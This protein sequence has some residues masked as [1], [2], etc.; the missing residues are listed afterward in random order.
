MVDITSEAVWTAIANE[1]FLVVGMV[2]ARGEARTAGVMHTVDDGRIWFTT[3]AHSWK[4]RH[5]AANPGISITVPIAKRIPF[6][7]WVKIPAATITFTGVA[8]ILPPEQLSEA[9]SRALL[10]GLELNDD[11]PII[12]VAVRPTG[13]FVT[14]GVGVS[15]MGMRDT[16]NAV[17]RA[18]VGASRG[19]TAPS[20]T[21]APTGEAV[22]AA[23][24]AR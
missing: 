14:Y 11:E 17:G 12:A 16:Q 20:G 9:A 5:L 21:P 24:A 22:A 7:P 3:E 1:N 19:A 4:A 15:I 23:S 13:D 2:S 8:E 6:V 10:H 18:A